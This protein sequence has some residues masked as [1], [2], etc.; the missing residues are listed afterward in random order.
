MNDLK[1]FCKSCNGKG[2]DPGYNEY[3]SIQ[4]KLSPKCNKCNGKGYNLS[5]YGK[6]LW[7]ILKP[8]VKELINENKNH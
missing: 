8:M 5:D 3:G 4:A 6:E 1:V 2:F 7:D